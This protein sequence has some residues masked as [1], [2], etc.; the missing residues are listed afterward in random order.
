MLY[1]ASKCCCIGGARIIKFSV[2][3]VFLMC[4]G[5]ELMSV[6]ECRQC[7]FFAKR[8]GEKEKKHGM[9]YSVLSG[10]S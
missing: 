5:Y 10:N 1:T 6:M 2:T 7:T 8:G 4:Y 3:L 9:V